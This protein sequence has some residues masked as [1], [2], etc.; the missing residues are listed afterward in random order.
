MSRPAS[1]DEEDGTL[2]VSK[3]QLPPKLASWACNEV[4]FTPRGGKAAMA[5]VDGRL[6]LIDL[7]TFVI[8]ATWMPSDYLRN[9][10]IESALEDEDVRGGD[11]EA[12][13]VTM[14]DVSP[15]GQWLVSCDMEG[16]VHVYSLQ[17][18]VY[19]ATLPQLPA[20][21][22]CMRFVPSLQM[23]NA[24]VCVTAENRFY[25][26]DVEA[27]RLTDWSRENHAAT[28]ASLVNCPLHV[29]G[30]TFNPAKPLSFLM[31]GASFLCNV[32]LDKLPAKDAN[33]SE[34]TVE[35]SKRKRK[36]ESEWC[37]MLH[38]YGPVLCAEYLTEGNLMV[39]ERPWIQVMAQLGGAFYTK[40]YG[41]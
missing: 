38:K 11:G 33:S 5:G 35:K 15:D 18:D 34:V 19:H 36:A 28:P 31:Y 26:F 14:L 16:V 41:K 40:R 37:T 2:D 22:T 32:N 21:M 29:M 25:I 10:T 8:E 9:A 7:E 30:I 13:A 39:A 27:A 1:Q 17:G 23:S 12:T 4:S 3:E 20:R 6:R 24:L